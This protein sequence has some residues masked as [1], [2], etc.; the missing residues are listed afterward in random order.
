MLKLLSMY[1]LLPFIIIKLLLKD[2]YF[3]LLKFNSHLFLYID[4]NK[5]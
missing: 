3:Y 2:T 4:M 5:F 1:K